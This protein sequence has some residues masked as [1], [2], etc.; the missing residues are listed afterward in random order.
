MSVEIV[1]FKI[2][3][4]ES[5]TVKSFEFIFF[6]DDFCLF[7]RMNKKY[8]WVFSDKLYALNTYLCVF[9]RLYSICN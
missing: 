7:F 4:E 1:K 9:V 3:L 8:I 2:R 5:T 6:S